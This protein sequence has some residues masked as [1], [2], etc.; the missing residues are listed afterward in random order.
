VF[1]GVTDLAVGLGSGPGLG[2]ADEAF[3]ARVA[4][5]RSVD[6]VVGSWCA[7]PAAAAEAVAAG[8]RY[9]LVGSDLQLLTQAMRGLGQALGKG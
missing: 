7:S 3:D 5:I 9:V 6:A 4:E 1:I 2:G 8:D